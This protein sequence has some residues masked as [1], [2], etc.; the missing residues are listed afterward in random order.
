MCSKRKCVLFSIVLVALF[1]ASTT[2][3]YAGEPTGPSDIFEIRLQV[4]EDGTWAV[5]SFGGLDLG[6][7]ST[8]FVAL[9]ETLNLGMAAPVIDPSLIA[10]A[11]SNNIETMALVKEGNDTTILVNNVPLS[12]VAL[13]DAAVKMVAGFAPQLEDMITTL[14]RNNIAVAVEFPEATQAIDLAG[15]VEITKV[16]APANTVDLGVTVSPKGEIL[17]V[18]GLDPADLGLALPEV[19]DTSAITQFGFDQIGADVDAGGLTL[20]ANEDKLARVAWSA[21]QLESIPS[22]VEQVAGVQFTEA[23][24]LIFDMAMGWLDDTQISLSAYVSDEP[25]DEMPAINIGRPIAVEV[26]NDN[27]VTVEG[28]TLDTGMGDTI[29]AL[30][31][32][33][34]NVALAWNGPKGEIVPVVDG[35]ALPIVKVDQEF[36]SAAITTFISDAGQLGT[37]A[38]TLMG[39]DVTVAANMEGKDKPDVAMLDYE[40][41]RPTQSYYS[42]VPQLTISR[43]DGGI[44]VNSETLPLEVL[45]DLTGIALREPIL[46]VVSTYADIESAGLSIGPEGITGNLNGG[47]LELKWDATVRDNLVKLA[48]GLALGEEEAVVS[49]SQLLGVDLPPSLAFLDEVDVPMMQSG[50]ATITQMQVGVDIS[51]QDEALQPGTLSA[52]AEGL[53]EF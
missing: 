7:N 36:I 46:Q 28:L 25:M 41:M 51:V 14:N 20:Y 17:S 38:N 22:I 11:T 47:T 39:L 13:S 50:L 6:L 9:A 35:M 1:L 12:E 37:L 19:I 15:R 26:R 18:A 23:T 10:M 53:L 32:M 34:D 42:V 29:G 48:V 40:P 16:A 31:G 30:R 49:I 4:D 44:S 45:E 2:T 52:F 33:F 3:V 21:G 5:T 27:L 43:A 24:D 8:T